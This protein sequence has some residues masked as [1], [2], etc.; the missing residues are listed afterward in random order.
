MS[1]QPSEGGQGVVDRRFAFCETL[2]DLYNDYNRLIKS[3]EQCGQFY[4][5]C[6]HHRATTCHHYNLVFTDGACSNNGQRGAAAGIGVVIGTGRTDQQFSIPITDDVDSGGTRSSQRAELLAAI[7][8][9]R[10]ADIRPPDHTVIRRHISERQKL[11]LVI[12]TDSEYVVKGMT[13]WFPVWKV[14]F[15]SSRH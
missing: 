2:L 1:L 4:A 13:E 10:R 11:C 6:C 8:G 9:L 5:L 3:C 15:A 7:E 12:T 14:R